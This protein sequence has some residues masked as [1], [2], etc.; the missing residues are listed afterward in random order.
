M[1]P[2]PL[3]RRFG[4]VIYDGLLHAAIWMTVTGLFNGLVLR[5]QALQ[6]NQEWLLQVTLFPLLLLGSFS[7]CSFFWLKNQQ[8]L[9]M[10]AWRLKI[11][12]QQNQTLSMRQAIAR[13][14]FVVVTLGIGT[15]WCIF[16]T[17]NRSLQD[18]VT[19]SQIKYVPAKG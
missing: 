5:G 11:V 16:D 1:L 14:G 8:T 15:F 6:P 10:Q 7:F 17:S 12:N 4:A 13:F 9:G 19:S 3:Y 2:V 18:I